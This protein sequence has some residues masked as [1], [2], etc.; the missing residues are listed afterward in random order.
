MECATRQNL[1]FK[2]N[3]NRDRVNAARSSAS[4][5]QVLRVVVL[6]AGKFSTRVRKLVFQCMSPESVKPIHDRMPFIVRED[7]YE[8]WLDI[9]V[10]SFQDFSQYFCR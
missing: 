2:A 4:I 1:V 8:Q 3:L 5:A 7:A 9:S 10:F 6:G